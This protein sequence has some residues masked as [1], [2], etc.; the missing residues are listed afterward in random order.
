VI[1]SNGF[2]TEINR[3]LYVLGENWAASDKA[4]TIRAL[5]GVIEKAAPLAETTFFFKGDESRFWAGAK[6]GEVIP[7]AGFFSTTILKTVAERYATDK[8][9][10]GGSP[11]MV[12]IRAPAG[13]KGLYIGGKTA[14]PGG[15]EYEFLLPR[16][17]LFRV[18]EKDDAHIL[19][20]V[21][22]EPQR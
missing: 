3:A 11:V 19:V 21:V 10:N 15:N 17:T 20:E 5:D 13:S 16:G 9:K 7:A 22:H 14:Y 1:Y 6:I 8:L 12:I 18:L 2:G 4:L